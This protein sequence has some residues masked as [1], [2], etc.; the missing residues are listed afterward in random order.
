MSKNGKKLLNENTIRRFMKLAEIDSLSEN[1]IGD[2]FTIGEQEE[3]PFEAAEAGAEDMGMDME[4]PELPPEPE[5]VPEEGGDVDVAELSG[6]VEALM[7]VVSRMTGVDIAVGDESE[8]EVP[9]EGLPE[10]E[11]LEDLEG[12]EELPPGNRGM[13]EELEGEEI[14]LQEDED[15][16]KDNGDE[17]LEEKLTNEIARRVAARLVKESRQDKMAEH[18]AERITRRLKNG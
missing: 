9:E 7:S 14:E 10:E 2:K 4:E 13:Y 8:E 3:E 17:K 16:D 18:L 6:A 5:E 11:P 12:E 15:E 1:F